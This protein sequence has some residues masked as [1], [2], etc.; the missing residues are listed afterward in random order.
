MPTCTDDPPFWLLSYTGSGFRGLEEPE[1]H[2]RDVV[3]ELDGHELS[4]EWVAPKFKITGSGTW[5]DWMHYP[6]PFISDRALELLKDLIKPHC[7]VMPVFGLLLV[8]QTPGSGVMM[9]P[10]V[11]NGKEAVQ[12][13]VQA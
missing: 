12:P 2:S 13:R 1:L 4:V 5:P 6:I 9:K 10:E 7:Q 11:A 8:S 3:A